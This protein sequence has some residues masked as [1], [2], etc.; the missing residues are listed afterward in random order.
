MSELTH[1][2]PIVVDNGTTGRAMVKEAKNI[3][4]KKSYRENQS[5][6]AD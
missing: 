6:D 3:V 1:G 2:L 4:L 5:L